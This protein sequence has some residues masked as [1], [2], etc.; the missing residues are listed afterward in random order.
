MNFLDYFGRSYYKDMSISFDDVAVLRI[1][2]V[3]KVI[4]D[5]VVGIVI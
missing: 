3:F 2:D 5:S 1:V 4:D